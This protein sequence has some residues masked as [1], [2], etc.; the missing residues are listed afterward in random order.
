[1]N[2]TS[3]NFV[4]FAQSARSV[5]QIG[6]YLSTID[7]LAPYAMIRQCIVYHMG[8]LAQTLIEKKSLSSL[9]LV[10][11][12][13]AANFFRL[14]IDTEGARRKKISGIIAVIPGSRPN[15]H[16][17]ISISA[18]KFWK[19]A[20]RKL[21]KRLYPQAMPVFF[22]QSEIRKNLS[23]LEKSLS[24]EHKIMVVD[25]TMKRKSV[26]ESVQTRGVETDRVW[27]SQTLRDSFELASERNMW[28]TSIQ[29]QV[30]HYESDSPNI[31]SVIATGRIYKEGEIFYDRYHKALNDLLIDL[32]ENDASSRLNLLQ[33]RGLRERDYIPSRPIQI[34]YTY[35]VFSELSQIKRFASVIAKYPKATKAVYH[36]NPYYHSSIADF[37]DGSSIEI[38]VLSPKRILLIPQAKSTAQAFER[39]ISHIFFEFQEGMVGEYSE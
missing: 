35:D 7:R 21:L 23:A 20:V 36:A 27:R 19:S 1:M 18:S 9:G 29:F 32:L 31:S 3:H 4:E 24:T 26:S 6:E 37:E 25:A 34:S 11:I 8:N 12:N 10:P 30:C 2:N 39:L 13:A 15:F 33:N 38:W 22:S 28:F 17:V 14:E 5:D 16:R